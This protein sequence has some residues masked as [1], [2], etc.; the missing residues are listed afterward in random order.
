VTHFHSTRE[1]IEQPTLV[2]EA[3]ANHGI[4]VELDD[5]QL[6]ANGDVDDEAICIVI[7]P[8]RFRANLSV[9]DPSL[10]PLRPSSPAKQRVAIAL[11]DLGVIPITSPVED[12]LRFVEQRF[13]QTPSIESTIAEIRKEQ[14]TVSQMVAEQDFEKAAHHKDQRE[15]LMDRLYELCTGGLQTE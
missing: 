11:C 14:Q 13:D 5:T 7:S 6:K 1:W 10:L 3:L 15:A 12:E 9:L 4:H 2:V 8:N